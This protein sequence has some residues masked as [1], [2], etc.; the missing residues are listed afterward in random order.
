MQIIQ[1]MKRGSRYLLARIVDEDSLHDGY[2]TTNFK[3]GEVYEYVVC[4]N[5]DGKQWDGGSY[6]G[7]RTLQGALDYF[8]RGYAI[9][10]SR[11]SELATRFKDGLLEVDEDYAME[12]FENECDMEVEEYKY[13]GIE[14]EEE[15]E[16]EPEYDMS[17]IDDAYYGF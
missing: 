17:G 6:F 3:V 8:N 9:T 12:W 16:K 13:F 2:I 14:V 15:E 11:L 1:L 10:Y 7:Y 4:S 5:F